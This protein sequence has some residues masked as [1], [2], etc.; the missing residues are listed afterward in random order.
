MAKQV[1]FSF[2]YKPD[3]WRVSQIRNI[4]VI[5]GNKAASDNKWEEVTKGG[6]KAIK[7]WIDDNMNYRTCVIVLVGSNTAGR[8]WIDYEI[9]KGWGDGKGVVGI[10]I[11]NIKDSDSNQATKGKNPF[12]KFTIGEGDKKEDLD[13]V[14][15]CYDPPYSGSKNVYSHIEDNIEDW[16]E[17]AI[18]IRNK[19]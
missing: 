18:E 9:K 13:K 14:V 15:K 1:F 6:E 5:E 12:S 17:K 3:N 16:I 4:G 7:K 11:H 19:Y 10:H 2:H 8:K